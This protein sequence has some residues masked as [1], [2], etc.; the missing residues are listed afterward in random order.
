MRVDSEVL[1]QQDFYAWIYHNIDLLRQRK[2]SEIQVDTLI[3]ELEDMASRD[4]DELE[5]RLAI[6][7]AHLLKW[8]YQSAHRSSSWRN[9]IVEQRYRIV[10]GLRKAPSLKHH[11]SKAIQE[12]YPDAVNIAVK[13]TGLSVNLFPASC[14]YSTEQLLDEDFYPDIH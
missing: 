5:S 1:Y 12:A 4:R 6:L 8:Q 14:P 3:E 11:W 7:I 10:R 2:F 13:E 9:S